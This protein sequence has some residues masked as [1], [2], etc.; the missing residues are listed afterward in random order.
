LDTTIAAADEAVRVARDNG[1]D[2]ALIFALPMSANFLADDDPERAEALIDESIEIS[3]RVGD[4]MGASNGIANKAMYAARRGDWR[5]ALQGAVDA[6]EQKLE[7]GDVL[8][9][10]LA[11]YP[12]GVALCGLG[13]YESAAVMFGKADAMMG[14]FGPNWFLLTLSTTD[15]TIRD[16]LGAARAL[17]LAAR[18][19]A[20]TIADAVA[21]LRTEALRTLAAP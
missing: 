11:L 19:A 6:A 20:L 16:A 17:T 13:S 14:R 18:G 4:H 8:F 3:I 15:A 12:A 2:S 21:L 1:I 9:I 10:A 7:L 5:T